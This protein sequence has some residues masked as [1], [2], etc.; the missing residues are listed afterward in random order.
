MNMKH[1]KTPVLLLATLAGALGTPAF[2][3]TLDVTVT[4]STAFRAITED[5]GQSLF[6]AGYSTTANANNNYVTY[7]GTMTGKIPSLGTTHVNLRMSFSGSISG[8]NTVVAGT[9]I[10]TWNPGQ[11]D[12][13]TNVAKVPDIALSDVYPDS[14]TPSID[15]SQFGSTPAIIG[16]I[17]FVFAKNNGSVLSAVTNL[18]KEEALLLM[19]AGGSMPVSYLSGT[20]TNYV[21]MVG[22][23]SGSGSRMTVERDISFVG[24]PNLWQNVGGS[25]GPNGDGWVLFPSDPASIAASV[26]GFASGSGVAG[27]VKTN[28]AA[29]GYMGL[30]DFNSISNQAVALTYNGVTYSPTNVITGKYGMWGK[31]HLCSRPGINNNAQL[32]AVRNALVNAITDSSYQHTNVTYYSQFCALSDM[33]VDRNS[34]GG[35][36]I[37]FNF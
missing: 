15:N 10:P 12:F 28:A 14:A 13:S 31:E 37:S 3:Q 34:D 1:T 11:T 26:D 30:S 24:V 27:T 2:A 36:I 19:T 4:G 7:S 5:R 18:T 33:Q 8:M 22:R 16:V 9:P 29:I 25:A 6:D 23:S 20:N 32:V 21:Y 17:P 35:A